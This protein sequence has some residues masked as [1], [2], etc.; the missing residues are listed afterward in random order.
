MQR[1]PRRV[2]MD[3]EAAR[4]VRGRCRGSGAVEERGGLSS[5]DAAGAAGQ[6]RPPGA[7]RAAAVRAQGRG[8][9][10]THRNLAGGCTGPGSRPA[11][12]P[13]SAERALLKGPV[14]HK[15]GASFHLPILPPS[16]HSIPPT[17]HPHPSPQLPFYPPQLPFHPPAPH[18][19]PSCPGSGSGAQAGAGPRPAPPCAVTARSVSSA[20]ARACAEPGPSVAPR[21][22]APEPPCTP[23]SPAPAADESGWRC[24][25][26]RAAPGRFETCSCRIGCRPL[27]SEHRQ[28][29]LL[30]RR[31]ILVPKIRQNEGWDDGDAGHCLA[32][33]RGDGD[34]E[35]LPFRGTGQW[36]RQSL[37][38]HLSCAGGFVTNH[39]TSAR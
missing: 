6:A 21:R 19:S 5:G 18:P 3:V 15:A 35:L 38:C 12:G 39:N 27:R 10:E 1:G 24:P 22:R 11:A 17:S 28:L 14:L 26:C 13:H 4:D 16:S 32:E 33:A 30:S 29:A 36:N 34:G 2:A 8:G 9:G 37:P 7:P 23:V 25:S 20:R 31:R